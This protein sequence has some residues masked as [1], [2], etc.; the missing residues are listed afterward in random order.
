MNNIQESPMQAPTSI[1]DAELLQMINKRIA[2]YKK[3]L[4]QK[5]GDLAYIFLSDH[6]KT[7]SVESILLAKHFDSSKGRD[8]DIILATKD[9]SFVVLPVAKA[10]EGYVIK[11]LVKLGMITKKDLKDN[12]FQQVGTIINLDAFEKA[13]ISK[14]FRPVPKELQAE[15]DRSRNFLLHFDENHRFTLTEASKKLDDIFQIMKNVA[16]AYLGPKSHHVKQK[17]IS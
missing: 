14:K 6:M 3:E 10:L 2:G 9:Y 15:W 17:I 13:V 7:L 1:T 8:V 4:K 5:V 11:L 16:E 12:P